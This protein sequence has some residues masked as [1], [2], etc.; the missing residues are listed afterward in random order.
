MKKIAAVAIILLIISFS[1]TFAQ[2]ASIYG[3][4]NTLDHSK[5]IGANVTL[6]G[7]V[8]GV[9]TNSIGYY[10][11][12]ALKP[13][14][15]TIVFS[16]IGYENI[17]KQF[18]IIA[19][20]S[21]E[22]NFDAIESVKNLNSIKVSTNKGVGGLEHLAE[23]DGFSINAT[24]KN[25]LIKLAKIDANLAMNNSRQIFG[26][27]PG[28]SIWES[29]GSGI[30]TS[31]GS[32]GLSP[33]R[34]WE[35]NTR[36][37]GYD[38][39]PD[40]MG[41]PEA[42]YTPPMEVVEK[43]EIVRGAS[44]LQ[45]GPQFGGLLNYVLRK[46]D[47][48]TKITF[49]S[50]NTIGSN[51]LFSTFNYIGGTKGKLNYTAYYQKRNGNGWR[52]NSKFDTDH[53]HI[54]L[55]YAVNNK[56][57]IGTEITYMNYVSQQAGGLTDEQFKQNPQQSSRARN[58][59]SAPWFIPSITAD[60]ILNTK[61]KLNFKAFG[62]LGERSSIGFVKAINVADD[63]KE[64]Q[65][66]RDFYKNIGAELRLISEYNIGKMP[67]TLAAGL[68][69]YNGN[70]NRKQLGT[71]NAGNDYSTEIQE[72]TNYKR[73]MNYHNTNFSI[74][75]E[76]VFKVSKKLLFTAG[77]RLENTASDASG[78]INIVNGVDNNLTKLSRNRTFVIAGIGAEY[79]TSSE[80][81]FYTNISQAYRPVLYSDLTP[82]ANTDVIDQNLSDA[83]GFNF[84]FGYRGKVNKFLNFDIDYFLI[85]YNNRI[86]TITQENENKIRYQ[87]RTN[88]GN[89]ISKGFEGYAEFDPL[90]AMKISKI[91]NLSIFASIAYI[92]AR[93]SN[94]KTTS[95]I[96]GKIVEGNLSN[97]KIE[98]AP[99]K[100]NRYG[101]TYSKKGTSI[102]WQM[103]DIGQTFADA[104]NTILP[105]ATATSGLIPA[106]KVQD[107]S[108]TIKFLK[109]YNVK[110][111]VNNLTNKM[112]FTRRSGGYPGPGILPADGRIINVS[113]GLK[114]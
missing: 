91:G 3:T 106:Y 68:R 15:Y 100:I 114:I 49:E 8:R 83:K 32:R 44:S 97:K 93:Y 23:I 39:T 54:E 16:H 61:T 104:S 98:N 26:R 105:N 11:I 86:G 28:I 6:K 78:R 19:S 47:I 36:M 45:Y 9:Q 72:N 82:P 65:I 76:N 92:D 74:F 60:Y 24:K 22:L 90:A 110:A 103:S 69:Y 94:F 33:N 46:P 27:V 59:F 40:P 56:L 35:F 34:S 80:T 63:L 111:S 17:E 4:A 77:I 10:T 88:I 41:Y 66:D 51:Q 81:E 73:D 58:W 102:T 62:T 55:G 79:N 84:D 13:G 43:I 71:G 18:E 52:Q 95:I 57:K 85:N 48:S 5:L 29:D 42:Y 20:E 12:S 113:V 87:Y 67:N 53:A 37:N 50:Q 64:R 101:I 96:D 14:K 31:I 112:Y 1:E 107:I 75:T 30:Q 25:E 2:K 70:T 108:A 7:T 99:R 109:H 89:S 21:K 38:I